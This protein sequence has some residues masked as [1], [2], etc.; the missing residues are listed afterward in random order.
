MTRYGGD[1]AWVIATITLAAMVV[2]LYALIAIGEQATPQ[3]PL[4]EQQR[5]WVRECATHRYLYDCRRVARELFP[6]AGP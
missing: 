2:G 1:L 6:E 5:D 3:T 4:T